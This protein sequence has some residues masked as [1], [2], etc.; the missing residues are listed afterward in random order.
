MTLF[1]SAMLV[2]RMLHE[3][4]R[5]RHGKKVVLPETGGVSEFRVSGIDDLNLDLNGGS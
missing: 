3:Q 5:G 1:L 4:P 2:K